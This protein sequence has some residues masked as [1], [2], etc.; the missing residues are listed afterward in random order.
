MKKKGQP[1]CPCCGSSGCCNYTFAGISIFGTA[2]TG[3]C[4]GDCLTDNTWLFSP[5]KLGSE[6]LFEQRINISCCLTH[7]V[8]LNTGG[9]PPYTRFQWFERLYFIVRW[10]FDSGNVTLRIRR[11]WETI[12]RQETSNTGLDWQD[13]TDCWVDPKSWPASTWPCPGTGGVLSP[14]IRT[15]RRDFEYT[16]FTIA[17][18]CDMY[19]QVTLDEIGGSILTERGGIP[20]CTSEFTYSG[21]AGAA[22]SF[23]YAAFSYTATEA[24]NQTPLIVQL[25]PAMDECPTH[26][27]TEEAAM[28]GIFDEFPTPV[29]L[30]S[31]T[32]ILA[33]EGL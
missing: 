12:L 21:S 18:C 5:E 3:I 19:D 10:I 20:L 13:V 30:D 6:C 15:Y 7:Q 24:C 8:I 11:Y 4:S 14:E 16:W 22:R 25:L 27:Y 1:G 33:T 28:E 32:A 17:D 29:A 9:G 2:G 23:N 31:Y 26:T